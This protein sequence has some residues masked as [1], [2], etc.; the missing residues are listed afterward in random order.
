MQSQNLKIR[1]LDLTTS[2]CGYFV[3][4]EIGLANI[5]SCTKFYF[6]SFTHSKFMEEGLKFKIWALDP[7]HAPFGVFCHG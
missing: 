4:C 7:D 3:M 2:V 6:S 5:Y 1:P